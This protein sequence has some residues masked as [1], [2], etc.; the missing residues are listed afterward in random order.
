MAK[1]FFFGLI[2]FVLLAS[3]VVPQHT[4]NAQVPAEIYATPAAAMP[5]GL[6]TFAGFGFTPDSAVDLYIETIPSQFLGTLPTDPLGKISGTLSIPA[7]SPGEYEIMASPND[8]FTTL[9]VLPEM[10]I[11][12]TPNSGPPGTIVHF[13]VNNLTAGQ[14]RLDYEGIPVY[15]PVDVAGGLFEGDFFVPADRPD[16][17]GGDAEVIALNLHAGMVLGT[18]QNFFITEIPN[19]DGY[20]ITNIVMPAQAVEPGFTFPITGQISPPP[21][22]PLSNYVLKI[23]WKAGSGQV[24]P[25]TVGT[26]IL[27]ANGSFSATARAPS[28]LSGDPFVPEAGGQVGVVFFDHGYQQNISVQPVPWLDPQDPVFKV[29]VVD[30]SD[31]PIQGAIVDIRAFYSDFGKVEGVTTDGTVLQSSYGNLAQHPNQIT[32]YLGAL[33]TTESDPFNCQTTNVYGRTDVNGEFEVKFDL[34]LIAM[35]GKKIFLGNLPKPTYMDTAMEIEFPLYVNALHKGFG[36]VVNNIPQPYTQELRFSGYTHLFYDV[37]TNHVVA[38]NPFIVK[39]PLLLPG[40]KITVPIVPKIGPIGSSASLVVGGFKNYLG[41]GIPMTAFG[42]FYSFPLAQF[43]DSLFYSTPGDIVISFEHDAT[44][45]GSLDDSNM[46]FTLEG[47]DYPFTLFG[48][49]PGDCGTVEY[50]AL[51]HNFYRFPAKFYTGIIEIRDES[52]PAN[53]TKHYIQL[54]VYPAPTWILQAQYKERKIYANYFGGIKLQGYQYPPGDPNSASNL[55]TNVPQVGPMQNRVNFGDEVAELLYPDK[56]TGMQ[57]KSQADGTVMSKVTGAKDYGGTMAGGTEIVIPSSTITVL[58]TGKIP[59]YRYIIGAP[60]IAGATLGADMWIDATLT[61]SGKIQF[62][63]NGTT[64][65]SLLVYP[66]ATVGVDAFLEGEVLFGLA[67]ASAHAQPDIG[68]GMPA[69]FVNGSLQDTE[70]CFHYKLVVSWKAKV[71]VCPL[72]K[73]W[74]DSDTVFNDRNPSSCT[75]PPAPSSASIDGGLIT[76]ETPEP[77]TASPALALD[78]LGH[79]LL[80]WSDET[81]NIQSKVLNGSSLVGQYPVTSNQRGIDPQVAFYAPNKAVAVWTESAMVLPYDPLTTSFE[82]FFQAQHLKYAM[83]NGSSWSAAQNLT[84]PEDSNGEGKVVLA[85]CLSTTAGCPA[86]GEVTAVWVRD[87]GA[88]YSERNFRLYYAAFN[89]GS[90][91]A[92]QAVDPSS[93][94]TDAEASAAYSPTGIAQ[95]VWTRDSGRSLSTSDD[96]RIYHRQL[97]GGSPVTAVTEPQLAVVEPSLAINSAGEMVLAFTVATDPLAFMG[98]QRQLYAAK[99]TCGESGCTWS[100]NALEDSNGRPV[101]AETPALTLNSNGQAQ[102]TYR[103][104]GFG[105]ATPGGPTVLPGDP[106]GT[107]IGTGEIAQ[108]FV[109]VSGA[110]I[111]KISPSYLTTGGQTVW[112]TT[113]IFDPVLN[114]TYTAASQGSGPVLPLQALDALSAQGYAV[115][116]LAEVPEPLAFTVSN[117]VPDFSVSDVSLSTLYPQTGGEPFTVTVTILN[118]GPAFASRGSDLD[119]ILAWDAPAGLGNLAGAYSLPE[120]FAAGEAI[121]VE[122]TT[123]DESLTLPANSHLPHTL[124]VQVN[125]QQTISESDYENNSKVKNLG[126]LPAP[127]GLSGVSQPGDSSVFLEWLPVDHEA[128]AGYRVYRS[129]DGRVFDPVGSSFGLGFVDLSGV[130][131]QTYLY[132]VVAYAA[133]GF[134]SDF[135]DPIQAQIDMVYPVFLP[136]VQR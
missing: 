74:S 62:M 133:D 46:K 101:H 49:T 4:V 124:Y 81:N 113:A 36:T 131:G 23:L 10:T 29:K 129:S 64:S 25:I 12:L 136:V 127:Q 121:V 110:P 108:A 19:P 100:T 91:G 88:A 117:S 22:G 79:T 112:Q 73:K 96:R 109:T 11:D 38:T 18:A 116:G 51:I 15:G 54:N 132:T 66:D 107:V 80:V 111:A 84:L 58:D 134:E 2:I 56:T 50:R 82:Q 93:T 55:D 128:L 34:E 20:A 57:Y 87:M 125:P 31:Q 102:I 43:P 21:Q 104:L 99:Q 120:P 17:L 45:F 106:L 130:A 35:M 28:L 77:P 68:M 33:S 61:T 97:T 9:T 3:P 16:P 13:S 48:N 5:G 105:A 75:P 44:L 70:K 1:K 63:S 98:N 122:F 92:P 76:A 123:A 27:L 67:S 85:G 114:Q 42:K 14:L 40:T 65:T 39:L 8:V 135:A 24:A 6:V 90:W 118:N 52:V 72:C 69:N 83:W 95:V 60:P 86:S 119:L 115:D 7:V 103:A 59:L 78:G 89:N 30:S 41:S 53:I 94:G 47:I 37:E 126:G 71:G 32:A 26:P